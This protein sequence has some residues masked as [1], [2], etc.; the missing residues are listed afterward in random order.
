MIALTT[1]ST[2]EIQS[3]SDLTNLNKKEY[4][5][6]RGYDFCPV[7]EKLDDRPPHWSKFLIMHR[8]MDSYKGF[9]VWMDADMWIFN[10]KLKLESLFD[11]KHLLF[12]SEDFNGI[13]AG[14]FAMPCCIES[15]SLLIDWYKR[16]KWVGHCWQ[17]Q[18]AMME[19]IDEG[20]HNKVEIVDKLIWNSYQSE[21]NAETNIIHLPAM[22]TQDRLDYFIACYKG[23]VK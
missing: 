9:V 22:S 19:W 11:D 4:C 8:L 14:I 5:K 15:Q 23:I 7:F 17:D 18:A 12:I 2:P 20:N 10:M 6:K 16:D 3:Y 13:N 21:K 1:L